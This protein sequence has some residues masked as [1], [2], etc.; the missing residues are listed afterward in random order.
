ME[1]SNITHLTVVN[2]AKEFGGETQLLIKVPLLA[3][4]P[5]ELGAYAGLEL[6]RENGKGI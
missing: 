6:N 1:L 5:H 3:F 2:E 4:G